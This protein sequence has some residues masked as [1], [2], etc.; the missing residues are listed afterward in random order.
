M[1]VTPVAVGPLTLGALLAI[2]G[3]L[4]ALLAWFTPAMHTFDVL[5]GL[6]AL[7]FVARLT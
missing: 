5:L 6:V 2:V 7:S 3:V 1:P 4:I